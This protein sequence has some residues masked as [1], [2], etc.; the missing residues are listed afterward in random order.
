MVQALHT[1][2]Y[3]GYGIVFIAFNSAAATDFINHE[4]R[5]YE[6]DNTEYLEVMGGAQLPLY[7][8]ELPLVDNYGYPCQIKDAGILFPW[9][10]DA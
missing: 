3:E 8:S 6:R 1:V 5:E 9:L 2:T 4:Q 7:V 10:E